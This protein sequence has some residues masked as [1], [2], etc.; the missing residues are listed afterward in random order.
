[1]SEWS[2]FDIAVGNDVV[3]FAG[4]VPAQVGNHIVQKI[5]DKN[6][7]SANQITVTISYDGS[8]KMMKMKHGAMVPF[9]KVIGYHKLA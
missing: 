3:V 1:M 9:I 8:K 4:K 5:Y 2:Q 6:G 7:G